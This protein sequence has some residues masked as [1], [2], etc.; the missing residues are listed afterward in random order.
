MDHLVFPRPFG[1]YLLLRS[2]RMSLLAETLLAWHRETETFAVVKRPSPLV[3]ESLTRMEA[4]MREGDCLSQVRHEAFPE[5]LSRGESGGLPFLAMEY[6]HGIAL[7]TLPRAL[8]ASRAR[9]GNLMALLLLDILEGITHLHGL[10]GPTG[11]W[12]HGDIHPANLMV[13]SWG[14]ARI[15]DLGLA[16]APME[17]LASSMGRRHGNSWRSSCGN[18]DPHTCDLV[19]FL[20]VASWLL[21]DAPED[22]SRRQKVESW[23]QEFHPHPAALP[24]TL[25]QIRTEL[26]S[27]IPSGSR[28]SLRR[29]LRHRVEPL[30][31]K[32]IRA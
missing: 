30:L 9:S 18:R 22:P 15:L 29:T 31:P 7:A 2:L 5:F 3:R 20:H 1:D 26:E 32:E 13:D 17:L 8:S 24:P 10:E 28:H 21:A 11:P 12:N 23:L 27:W 19:G 14:H 25:E 6:I 16:G 4:F